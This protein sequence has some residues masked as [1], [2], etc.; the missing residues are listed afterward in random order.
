VTTR[1]S[2][3]ILVIATGMFSAVAIGAVD[4][5]A[6]PAPGVAAASAPVAAAVGAPARDKKQH[7]STTDHSKLKEL[8]RSFASGPEVT[9]ACIGCHTEAAKQ[10]QH[11]KHWTWDVVNAKTNQRLGKH[12]IINNFC[13]TPISNEKDCMACHVGYGWKDGS[14]DFTRQDNV[15]CLVCHDTTGTYRKLSG[16]AGHPV[17]QRKE[18]P[19]KSGKFI[20]AVDLKKVAQNVGQT[21]RATCGACHFYGAG[22]DGTK[23]GDLDSTLKNAPKYLD[24]HMDAQ[25]LNFTC[26]TCHMTTGHQVGG[27]RYLLAAA[28]KGPAH[29]R[30]KLDNA[31]T[32]CQACHGSR[33]HPERAAKLNDHTDKLACQ[34]CHIPQFARDAIGTELSWDW[35]TATKMGPDGKP[36]LIK[37]SAGRRAFDSRKGNFVWDSYVTP[38]YRWFNGETV[39]K[40]VGDKIDPSG[41]VHINETGGSP[42][43]PGSRIW[44][45]KV[46]RGKQVYDTVNKTLI[47]AHT[48]GEDINALWHS[49][50]WNKAIRAGMKT[51]NLPY[52]G[53]YG[54]VETEMSWPITHMVAPKEDALAC[55]QCHRPGGRLQKIAG[56]Y[57]PGRDHSG[58]LEFLGWSAVL[59]SLIASIVHGVARFIS[60]RRKGA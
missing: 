43:D 2:F 21:S 16:D 3:S 46:H 17:Y 59:L 40:T 13:T 27:S 10:V 4:P 7:I 24:V 5:S 42:N 20:E 22:G 11:T 34:S 50:D 18:F 38:E 9:K 19:A 26:A 41:V 15:D 30:G 49:F 47:V 55:A 48:A 52:S 31:P 45:M 23:H 51:A 56:I 8:Q 44:P 54:F 58:V 39:Y 1:R 35:S 57:M 60:L 25:G 53:Q 32:S 6:A 36:A 28:E 14:F 29:L 33:P 37:D 12:N